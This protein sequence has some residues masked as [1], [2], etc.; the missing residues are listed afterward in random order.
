[1]F[2]I[3]LKLSVKVTAAQLLKLGRALVLIALLV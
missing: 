1:M 3:T 2:E